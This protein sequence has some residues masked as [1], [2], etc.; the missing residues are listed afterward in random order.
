MGEMDML[1]VA[2]YFAPASTKSSGD[3]AKRIC[4][5]VESIYDKHG[6]RTMILWMADANGDFGL[7]RNEGRMV[8]T[9]GNVVGGN[10]ATRRKQQLKTNEQDSAGKLPSSRDCVARHWKHFSRRQREIQPN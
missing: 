8:T 1:V 3:I 2:S 9:K 10:Q 4:R 5:W 6:K 7:D